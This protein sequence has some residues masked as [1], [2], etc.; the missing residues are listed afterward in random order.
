MGPH[1]TAPVD[2][3][4]LPEWLGVEQVTW[5]AESSLGTH[6]VTGHLA[7]GDRALECDVLACDL[8][9]P[10]PVLAEKW[11]SAAHHAWALGEALLVTYDGR[12]TIVAPG[13][14]VTVETVL[15]AVRRLVRAVGGSADRFTVALR[16]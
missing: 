13:T 2:A 3:F 11:R 1:E 6:H 14:E 10:L 4:E 9:Y 7:S 5:A 12:M 8:A 15:D 16:L